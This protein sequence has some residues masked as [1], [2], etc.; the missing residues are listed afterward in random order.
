MSKPTPY[1]AKWGVNN[2]TYTQLINY[3]TEIARSC[4]IEPYVEF[5]PFWNFN[6]N[7]ILTFPVLWIEPI[8]FKHVNSIQG[9]RVTKYSFYL[10]ALDRIDKGDNNYQNILNEMDAFLKYLL[11]SIRE[12][13]FTRLNYMILDKQDMDQK[14]MLEVTDEYTNGWRLKLNLRIPDIYTPCNIPIP[15]L[16]PNEPDGD[17]PNHYV[18]VHYVQCGYVS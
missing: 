4:Y 8:D 3:I 6:A 1:F 16:D 9:I 14:V 7:N 17:C 2:N 10:Y 12:S 11:A 15:Y 18:E 5:G 13:E